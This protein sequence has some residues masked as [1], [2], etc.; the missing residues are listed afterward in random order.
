MC[1]SWGGRGGGGIAEGRP[2]VVDFGNGDFHGSG[3][4][5]WVGTGQTQFWVFRLSSGFTG[6]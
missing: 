6:G 5:V 3:R 4:Y 1:W 2:D